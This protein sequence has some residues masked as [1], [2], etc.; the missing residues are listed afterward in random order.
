MKIFNI[1][2]AHCV[3]KSS[4]LNDLKQVYEKEAWVF[5]EFVTGLYNLG[6][7]I[8]GES[9]SFVDVCFSEEQMFNLSYNTV[10][11][12][13]LERKKFVQEKDIKYIFTDR[14]FFDTFIYLKYFWELNTNKN[15]KYEGYITK[16]K[17][18]IDKFYF[19]VFPQVKD[20]F[21]MIF[22]RPFDD[23]FMEHDNIRLTDHNTKLDVDKAIENLLKDYPDFNV[24]ALQNI[25]HESRIKEIQNYIKNLK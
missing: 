15:P 25:E 3:G 18:A 14:G 4:I 17:T 22:V 13:L 10:K 7:I 21:F 9:R 6:F 16:L 8:N 24:L 23:K 1:I 2:G 19:E 5:Q 11:Y 20:K 12:F